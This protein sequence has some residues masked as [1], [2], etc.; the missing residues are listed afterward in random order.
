[1]SMGVS[2]HANVRIPKGVKQGQH[3]RLAGLGAPSAGGAGDLF[4]EVAFRPHA[5]YRVDGR[6]VYLDLPVTPWETA[7]GATVKAPTPNGPVELKIPP[8]ST[9]GRRLRLRGRGIPGDPPGDLYVVLN[10]ETPPADSDTA[11]RLYRQMAIELSF[12]PRKRLGV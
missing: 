10:I 6:D 4:L 5:F 3:I 11:R 9:T 7:L 8:G 2:A 1:M 12:D